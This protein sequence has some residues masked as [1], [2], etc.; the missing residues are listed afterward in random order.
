MLY[1]VFNVL[2]ADAFAPVAQPVL[3]SIVLSHDL[4]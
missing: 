3:D 2:D 4:D 1:A